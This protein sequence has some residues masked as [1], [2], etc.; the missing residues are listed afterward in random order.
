[1]MECKTYR[2]KS[3][4]QSYDIRDSPEYK[5]ILDLQKQLESKVSNLDLN[6]LN[7][8]T[9]VDGVADLQDK[10]NQNLIDLDSSFGSDSS[11]YEELDESDKIQGRINLSISRISMNPDD[12]FISDNK[13]ENGNTSGNLLDEILEENMSEIDD[14][15]NF[16]R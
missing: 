14:L 13:D 2:I 1:M 10:C 15:S 5:G 6:S 16:A 8:G 11:Y 7:R 3:K 9:D 4:I 12:S